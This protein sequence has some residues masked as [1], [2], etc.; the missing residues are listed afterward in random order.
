MTQ[1]ADPHRIRT[2]DELRTLYEMPAERIVRLKFSAMDDHVIRFLAASPLAFIATAGPGGADNSPRGGEPGFVRVI[3]R[4]LLAIPDWPGNNKL[5]T[6]GNILESDGTCG[7]VFL[8]PK[9]DAF[10]RINGTATLS[11]DPA[12]LARFETQGRRPKLVILVAVGEVYFHCGKALRRSNLWEPDR[13]RVP[14]DIPS[15]GTIIRDQAGMAD[16][17]VADIDGMYQHALA[18]ELY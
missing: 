6:M 18:H 4:R 2:R 15:V 1:P 12:H 16:T 3:D 11:R 14:A 9:Q 10:L 7:L 8:V 13:W 5:E 17:P